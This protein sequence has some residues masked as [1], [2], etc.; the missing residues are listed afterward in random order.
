[1]PRGHATAAFFL[2]DTVAFCRVHRPDRRIANEASATAGRAEWHR[3]DLLLPD[4]P[5][6]KK[7]KERKKVRCLLILCPHYLDSLEALNV[8]ECVDS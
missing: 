4:H 3:F 6:A 1:M 7:K 8:V 5:Q 2:A